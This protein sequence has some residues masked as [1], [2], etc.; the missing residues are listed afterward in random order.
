MSNGWTPERRAR[1][2]ALIRT[3][4]PWRQ[5]TGPKTSSGK[6]TAS[7]NGYKGGHRQMLRQL[8]RLVSAEIKEA[9]ELLTALPR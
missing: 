3:W 1:Q 5:S 2:A 7:K 8:S 9:R 4:K 6:A